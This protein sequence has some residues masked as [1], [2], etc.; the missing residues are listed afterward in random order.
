MAKNTDE[1]KAYW[2]KDPPHKGDGKAGSLD[3]SRSISEHR[4]ATVPYIKKFM[5]CS[6]FEDKKVLEIGCGAGSDLIE[7]AKAGAE[8]YGID[9]TKKAIALAKK[10]F[11]CESGFKH[12]HLLETYNGHNIPFANQTFD[13]VY[14]CGVLHHTPYMDHL[15]SEIYSVLKSCGVFKCM[16]YHRDSLLY[17]YSIL[18]NAYQYSNI[19]TAHKHEENLSKHSEFRKGCPY[20]RVFSKPDI[21]NRLSYFSKVKLWSDYFVYDDPETGERKI[22]GIKLLR[23]ILS[24]KQPILT[25]NPQIDCFFD[26]LIHNTKAEDCLKDEKALYNKMSALF[27]WHLL[28]EAKK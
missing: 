2:E 10:R 18:C 8:V 24:N 15:F 23:Q 20:T 16:L 9:I 22:N 25:R 3:W 26:K 5:D 11:E 21:K 7:Y 4:Y 27:G 13:L 17:N 28:I 6:K 19:K 14:S 1:I 12:Q